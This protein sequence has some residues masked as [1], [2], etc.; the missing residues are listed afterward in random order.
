[1]QVTVRWRPTM[2]LLIMVQ[3]RCELSRQHQ[4]D[5]DPERLR[6]EDTR[7]TLRVTDWLLGRLR[8]CLCQWVT[9]WF[10]TRGGGF[11]SGRAS[12]L[13]Q[14]AVCARTLN[15]GSKVTV[16]CQL[17][18]YHGNDQSVRVL[19]RFTLSS[20]VSLGAAAAD[21]LELSSLPCLWTRLSLLFMRL[22]ARAITSTCS[23]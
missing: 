20:A 3:A 1:M 19:L 16:R 15:Y 14:L 8:D 22:V 6:F 2:R 7:Q 11:T 18:L 12:S 4:I 17:S 21:L 5:E 23:T 13:L 9:E 10:A